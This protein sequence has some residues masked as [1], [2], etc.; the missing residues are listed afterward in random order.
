[1]PTLYKEINIA[2]GKF[3]KVI[4]SYNPSMANV[5]SSSSFDETTIPNMSF[6]KIN[7]SNNR[8]TIA[9]KF[10]DTHPLMAY[11]TGELDAIARWL[12]LEN[13][14]ALRRFNP[15]NMQQFEDI[16]EYVFVPINPRV[17]LQLYRTYRDTICFI[18]TLMTIFLVCLK[19]LGELVM[20]HLQ[21]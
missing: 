18:K 2:Y 12:S 9:T 17:N 15:S 19:C 4:S 7:E 13:K 5:I 21:K 8:P 10:T 3:L 1:M 16:E 14:Y 20:E 11:N 6:S